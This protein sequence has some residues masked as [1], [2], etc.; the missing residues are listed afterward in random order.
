MKTKPFV[1][2]TDQDLLQSIDTVINR[3]QQIR[4]LIASGK[5]DDIEVYDALYDEIPW[6]EVQALEEV[7]SRWFKTTHHKGE[8][9]VSAKQ[10][11]E[12][13]ECQ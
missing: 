4:D 8:A 13:L 7:A 12:L 9:V 11:D 3:Y 10:A 2:A 5:Y 6:G 1:P